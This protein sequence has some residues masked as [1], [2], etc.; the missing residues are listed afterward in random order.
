MM[1]PGTKKETIVEEKRSEK[2]H[3]K[4]EE[5]NDVD[6]MI[7]INDED[8]MFAD[9]DLIFSSLP[10]FPCLSSPTANSSTNLNSNKNPSMSSASSSSSSSSSW[11]FFSNEGLAQEAHMQP[12]NSAMVPADSGDTADIFGD[13]ELWDPSNP[14]DPSFLFP[15]D[16]DAALQPPIPPLPQDGEDDDG[17]NSSTDE[18]AKIFLEWLKN[19]RDSISPEDL[20]SIKLKKS[21]IE[22]AAA[23]LGGGKQGRSQLLKLILTWVQNNHLQ[24]KKRRL[25]SRGG[26]HQ[27]PETQAQFY[28]YQPMSPPAN[29][30]PH[31]PFQTLSDQAAN[32]NPNLDYWNPM[33]PVPMFNPSMMS[34]STSS[35]VVNSQPF[36][37]LT[38]FHSFSPPPPP[39]VHYPP[40]PSIGFPQYP[41]R[42]N[43]PY[44]PMYPPPSP[45]VGGSTATATKEARKKRMAR[46][47][48]V[49]V[50]HQQRNNQ[51][52]SQKHS[53]SSAPPPPTAATNSNK[54]L[55][56]WALLSSARQKNLPTDSAAGSVHLSAKTSNMHQ[57]QLQ[58]RNLSSSSS[59][60]RQV[61]S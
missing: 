35:I 29:A 33:T 21:T 37:P 44:P 58:S 7:D 49:S 38:D 18:M 20:R 5:G 2:N 45:S 17:N 22:C 23:R 15:D 43:A 24:N 10:D 34:A 42:Y 57:T 26:D 6:I 27:E 60:K 3:E 28:N 25:Q 9:E 30:Y 16:Y 1:D 8:L 14:L 11:A 61:S 32:P 13:I 36:S 46:Q 51:S 41:T 52:H 4:L 48:R 55:K 50:L 53:S 47:R 39:P 59:D 56:N 19:N 12:Q 54:A 40:F 31:Y